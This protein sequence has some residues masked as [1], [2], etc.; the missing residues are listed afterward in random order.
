MKKTLSSIFIWV[1]LLM[2]FVSFSN[3]ASALLSEHFILGHESNKMSMEYIDEENKK[4]FVTTNEGL[5]IIEP[6]TFKVEKEIKL[7]GK[8]FDFLVIDNIETNESPSR[9]IILFIE[10]ENQPSVIL[11]SLDTLQKIW[12]FTS[13]M[14]GYNDVGVKID[15]K[16]PIFDYS[17]TNENLFLVAGYT[18]Y[19]LDIKTGKEKWHYN[20]SDNIWSVA[21]IND[22]NKDSIRDIVIS[23]QPESIIS[24]SGNNG[25]VL[26]K[27]EIA[28]NIDISIDNKMLGS[29]KT[30][31]WDL[32]F[33]KDVIIATSE[34]GNIYKVTTDE[35]KIIRKQEIISKIP[36]SII[37]QAYLDGD[38]VKKLSGLET[39]KIF[40]TR[41]INDLNND[42]IN[43]L[44]VTTFETNEYV[45]YNEKP[46]IFIL[47]GNSLNI[48]GKFELSEKQLLNV[49]VSDDL[50]ICLYDG[51][52]I[53]HFN[54]K[55][56]SNTSEIRIDSAHNNISIITI[57]DSLY[58]Y[59]NN[60]YKIDITD[61]T[62]PNITSQIS[63]FQGS[64]SLFYDDMIY[65]LYFQFDE[66]DRFYKNYYAIECYSL[67]NKLLWKYDLQD[68]Y[69][70][71]Y[72]IRDDKFIFINEDK[73]LIMLKDGEVIDSIQLINGSDVK[74]FTETLDF[75]KDGLKDFL[76]I[77][78][79]KEFQI[80]NAG[81]FSETLYTNYLYQFI[82]FNDYE[83]IYPVIN[84]EEMQIY[85]V[86]YKDI[87]IASIDSE[88]NVVIDK[89]IDFNPYSFWFD[90][91][92][93][94]TDKDFDNDGYNDLV[95]RIS[96]DKEHMAVILYSSEATVGFIP[97]NWDFTLYPLYEDYNNDGKYEVMIST[98]GEDE[99]G[100][101]NRFQIVNPYVELNDKEIIFEKRFYEGNE[102]TF[103]SKLKPFTVVDDI[104]GD[105]IKD[106]L[107]LVN[108]YGDIYI[109]VY[110]INN[111]KIVKKVIPISIQYI[112]QEEM[113]IS[114]IGSPGAFIDT[115]EYNY[116]NYLIMSFVSN[117]K[118]MT[119]VSLLDKMLYV[120]NFDKRVFDYHIVDDKIYYQLYVNKEDNNYYL[121][122]ASLNRNNLVLNINENKIYN[123]ASIDL[124]WNTSRDVAYYKIYLDGKLVEITTNKEINIPLNKGDNLIGIGEV[125]ASGI[126]EI[127]YFQIKNE[128][129][130][131]DYYYIITAVL[132]ALVFLLP[133][134]KSKYRR[135]ELN[136]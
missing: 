26:W 83:F 39:Y 31:I 109:Q 18:V 24:L 106:V 51:K 112:S 60:L 6:E 126:E 98:N 9:D 32:H 43:D 75:N 49:S 7:K 12:S 85:L 113:K 47:D 41:I 93:I 64:D 129:E 132:I 122:E 69:F 127:S 4:L 70:R 130:S 121:E 108:R 123:D 120:S 89:K 117:G 52:K 15:K 111:D 68:A 81:D 2:C 84:N 114:S 65:K 14:K 101:H 115:F 80:I 72:Q 36:N 44:L 37:Y 92:N 119:K 105:G 136:E 76:V 118:I 107:V 90:P 35:G 34:D 91:H 38:N 97:A 58:I 134:S 79:N 82:E 59:S 40:N 102:L 87:S 28:S 53:I 94:Y 95:F 63:F 61:P 30:N 48:I 54:A 66:N 21:V 116:T 67:N 29:I 86:S 96:D 99:L 73:Y 46:T 45:N 77:F 42:K 100:W 57:D 16:I 62:N 124:K 103:N 78:H 128:P 55:D 19:N 110:N 88:F 25:E 23:V 133:L 17:F 11:Y 20:Y 135:R 22:I 13:Y 10:D 5:F 125:L 3:K 8:I 104:T 33:I 71:Y 50:D 74:L 131:K 1:L 27:S 56:Y